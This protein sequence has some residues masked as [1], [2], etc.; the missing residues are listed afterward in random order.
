MIDLNEVYSLTEFQWHAKRQLTRLAR[1]GKPHVLTVNGRP[2][3]VI[4]DAL[5]YQR[6]LVEKDR[7]EAVAGIR[8]GLEAA[9]NGAGRPLEDVLEDLRRRYEKSK[10]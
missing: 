5:S 1:S 6:L 2:A 4:Q 9:Q 3:L 10:R 7:A 8:R